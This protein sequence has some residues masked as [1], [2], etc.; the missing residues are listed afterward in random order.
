LAD[1]EALEMANWGSAMPD[2]QSKAGDI[3]VIVLSCSNKLIPNPS[4]FAD[5]VSFAG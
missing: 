1:G 5:M 3:F 4:M 2:D